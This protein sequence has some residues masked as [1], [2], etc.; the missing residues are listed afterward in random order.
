MVVMGFV[1]PKYD[2]FRWLH[3]G[4]HCIGCGSELSG[5]RS[6][7]SE[8]VFVWRADLWG[9]GRNC[10]GG[11]VLMQH[12]MNFYMVRTRKKCHPSGL[13]LNSYLLWFYDGKIIGN[14]AIYLI[15]LIVQYRTLPAI[16]TPLLFNLHHASWLPT[17]SDG[18]GGFSAT[19]PSYGD[20][21][22]LAC[23]WRLGE[24]FRD[25]FSSNSWV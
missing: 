6:V 1:L 11:W 14:L 25:S 18:I 4:Y 2:E 20:L 24:T 8:M 19:T 15:Y 13:H 10:D 21:Y 12:E 7:V 9:C 17:P 22:R 23:C 3:Q 16:S 5:G